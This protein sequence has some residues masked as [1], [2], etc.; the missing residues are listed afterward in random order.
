MGCD[1]IVPRQG[2]SCFE[3][4]DGSISSACVTP[5]SSRTFGSLGWTGVFVMMCQKHVRS[6]T[7]CG[8]VAHGAAA[9]Y[10]CPESVRLVGGIV[11]SVLW[12]TFGSRY[13]PG[14][15]AL[16]GS[17]FPE[18]LITMNCAAPLVPGHGDG[19]CASAR[20][21]SRRNAAGSPVASA[22]SPT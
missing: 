3:R 13:V 20:R 12:T 14:T 15:L 4:I 16:I 7:F 6:R 22:R 1:W 10:C 11:G 19:V 5:M 8:N 21:G 18:V 9:V 2:A 17:P